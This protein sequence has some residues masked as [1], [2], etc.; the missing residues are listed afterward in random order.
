[1]LRRIQTPLKND[2]PTMVDSFNQF[3]GNKKG[4]LSNNP[5]CKIIKFEKIANDKN[6][7]IEN[8]WSRTEKEKLNIMDENSTLTFE[9]F[10]ELLKD[11]ITTLNNL[12][13]NLSIDLQTISFKTIQLG[14]TKYFKPITTLLGYTQKEYIP[15][16]TKNIYNIP[17]FTAQKDAVAFIKKVKNKNPIHCSKD[18][19]H[20]SIASDGDGTAGTNIIIHECDYYLNSSR[21]A[22]EIL[23]KNILVKYLYYVLQVIK[24][25]YGFNYS[26]KATLQNQSVVCIQLPINNNDDFDIDIQKEI[27]NKYERIEQ[28]K[29]NINEILKEINSVKIVLK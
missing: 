10:S 5:L 23:D 13:Y 8:Y 15:L 24:D 28:L 25:E 4:Y 3:K 14:D 7:I 2:L 9:D 27:I 11:A 16:N 18:N 21:I 22:Y 20:I 1:L 6:W 29:E 26:H 19:P 17:I 12:Q